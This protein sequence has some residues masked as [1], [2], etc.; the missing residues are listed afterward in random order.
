MSVFVKQHRRAGAIVRA[1]LRKGQSAIKAHNSIQKIL[2]RNYKQ[3]FRRQVKVG[4]NRA[5]YSDKLEMAYLE[6]ALELRKARD[7]FTAKARLKYRVGAMLLNQDAPHRKS[8]Y[9]T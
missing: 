9:N 4:I 2:K 7:Y 3:Y 6:R 5:E 8:R 1:Y